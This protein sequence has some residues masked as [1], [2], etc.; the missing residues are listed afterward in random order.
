MTE[1]AL[2]RADP[3]LKRAHRATWAMGDYPALAAKVIPGLGAV[4]VEAC[5]IADGDAVLDVAAGSGN[6][7]I[8]AALAGA[9]AVACDLTPELFAA[10]QQDAAKRG[11]VVEWQ[12][13]DAEALPFPDG[14]FDVV[15]SCVGVMFA[16]HH[17]ACADE[18]LRVCRAGGTIGL[19]NWTP[20]GFV[21]QMFAA[22]RPYV[23]PP[24]PGAE[25]PPLWGDENHVRDLLGGRVSQLEMIRQVVTVDC[26]ADAE[27]FL[28]YFKA[29]Y[30]P[31]VAAY[32][33]LES[34]PEEA[35]LLDRDLI[36]LARRHIRGTEQATMEWEYL[37]VTARKTG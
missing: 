34:R 26:F 16:P 23:A 9:R 11:A 17:Q 35:V 13:A 14:E 30:G 5:G 1:L 36:E 29:N 10:G 7:A 24:P 31:T 3:A 8:P 32:K 21:G 15:C 33:S 28:G 27:D 4:L 20:Q 2:T 19:I 22:M 6:A 12:E 18:V 37:L 25:P